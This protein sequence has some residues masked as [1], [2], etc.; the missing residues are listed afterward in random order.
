MGFYLGPKED[1]REWLAKHGREIDYE[2]AK[3]HDFSSND[4]FLVVFLDNGFF[5]AIGVA[6]SAAEFA[7]FT[8]LEDERPKQFYLVSQDDLHSVMDLSQWSLMLKI[9]EKTT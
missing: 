5:T 8:H 4:E 2:S 3:E 6:Y 1:N 9:R 7:R